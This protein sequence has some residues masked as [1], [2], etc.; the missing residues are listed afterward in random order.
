MYFEFHVNGILAL[1][2]IQKNKLGVN[3]GKGSDVGNLWT[4]QPFVF[5]C[6]CCCCFRL[7][8]VQSLWNLCH[9]NKGTFGQ[10]DH[11]HGYFDCTAR[12][13]N[14][15]YEIVFLNDASA[16]YLPRNLHTVLMWTRLGLV[17]RHTTQVAVTWFKCCGVNSQYLK[18]KF[19]N[20]LRN[21]IVR[22]WWKR[23]V[24]A[25]FSSNIYFVTGMYG[26]S[27]MGVVWWYPVNS[28]YNILRW[29]GGQFM[30]SSFW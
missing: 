6:C 12:F 20:K 24:Y 25:C 29:S 23:Q 4:E 19:F 9:S 16:Y 7:W 13:L 5:C 10:R 1:N 15:T 18:W 27:H 26:I 21:C 8:S 17:F 14:T 28:F 22:N 11:N 3:K 30:L 2:N